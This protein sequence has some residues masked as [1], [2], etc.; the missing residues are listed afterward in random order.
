MGVYYGIKI[1]LSG[2]TGGWEPRNLQA[3]QTVGEAG[4]PQ[5]NGGTVLVLVT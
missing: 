1:P 2:Y 5:N 4:K 3:S